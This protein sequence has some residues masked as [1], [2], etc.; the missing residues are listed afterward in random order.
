MD[1]QYFADPHLAEL[2]GAGAA[3][4]KSAFVGAD[5]DQPLSADQLRVV[6]ASLAPTGYLGGR[7]DE[8]DGG[9][10]FTAEEFGA[11]LEGVAEVA[12]YLSNHNVQREIARLGS[13]A[14]K[15][16]WMPRLL[17]G[18]LIGTI[19]VTE[20]Q[21][22]TDLS[23]VEATLSP[24]DDGYTLTGQKLWAVHTMTADVAIVLARDADGDLVRAIVDLDQPSVQRQ[25]IPTAGLRFLTFGL[26]EFHRTPV[27]RDDLLDVGGDEG[28]AR[29]LAADRALSAIQATSVAQRAIHATIKQL[30]TRRIAGEPVTDRDAI[31]LEVGRMSASVEAARAYAYQALRFLDADQRGVD[32]LAAGAKAH[33]TEV[34]SQVC[35]RA[36][37]LC[38]AEGLI[39]GSE[40]LRLRD[41]LE[42]LAT[43]HGTSLV[44]AL[45]WGEYVIE[46]SQIRR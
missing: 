40:V 34:C 14:A 22:G 8:A 37:E 46:Q 18:D 43:A 16:R 12:P 45:D 19:A 42:M 7:V 30:S 41:D 17:R 6:F 23:G 26:L 21:A 29:M 38:S 11:L 25:A 3:L 2:H 27:A 13:P 36:V 4:A 39:V 32:A 20:T 28:V 33:A 1:T 44:N 24:A 35:A 15:D 5:L 31:R 9:S 10:G